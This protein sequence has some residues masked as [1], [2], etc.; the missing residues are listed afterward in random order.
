MRFRM[1]MAGTMDLSAAQTD[2]GDEVH[3]SHAREPDRSWIINSW[4]RQAEQLWRDYSSLISVAR[5]GEVLDEVKR[6]LR[7]I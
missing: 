6:D 7:R 2:P 4:N 3:G 5:E 1:Q